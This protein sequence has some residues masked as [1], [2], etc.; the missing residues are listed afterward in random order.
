MLDRVGLEVDK[1]FQVPL[2]MRPVSAE[3][4]G[5]F[6]SNVGLMRPI[7][8][9]EN[10][11]TV[12]LSLETEAS[13]KWT[14]EGWKLDVELPE[15]L[16]DL[17]RFVAMEPVPVPGRPASMSAQRRYM[18]FADRLWGRLG[19]EDLPWSSKKDTEQ[20][21]DS[22]RELIG[23]AKWPSFKR[24]SWCWDSLRIGVSALEFDVSR[25]ALHLGFKNRG[26]G[27]ECGAVVRGKDGSRRRGAWR[28]E[29]R[30]R[31]G[32]LRR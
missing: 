2:R 20:F 13:L 21:G 28:T 14:T 5:L 6:A 29:E 4:V 15:K 32:F 12:S 25:Y 1:A 19:S 30:P 17:K 16:R 27:A 23:L 26:Q 18:A 8:S 24:R 22:L 9:S 10:I 31:P 7:D 3:R 11:Q